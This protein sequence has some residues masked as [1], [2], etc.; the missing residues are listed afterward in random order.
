LSAAKW[1]ELALALQGFEDA[2]SSFS[3]AKFNEGFA[4][5][6]VMKLLMAARACDDLAHI[7]ALV[8]WEWEHWLHKVCRHW[9]V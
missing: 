5:G 3:I 1:F 8:W 7:E 6:K 4:P 9:L 2:A